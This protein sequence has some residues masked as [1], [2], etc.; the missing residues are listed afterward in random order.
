MTCKI[1][2]QYF[3]AIKSQEDETY[4]LLSQGTC[5]LQNLIDQGLIHA[6][7]EC[8]IISMLL[9]LKSELQVEEET[10]KTTM[11]K[12]IKHVKDLKLL[13]LEMR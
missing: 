6:N 10:K 4:L 3:V 12:F 2:Q 9:C 11:D 8:I 7:C 1:L 5:V 13:S